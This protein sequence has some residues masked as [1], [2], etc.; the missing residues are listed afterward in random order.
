MKRVLWKAVLTGLMAVLFA[1]L[2]VSAQA[3]T[4]VAYVGGVGYETLEEAYAAGGNTILLA[5]NA[6]ITLSGTMTIDRAVTLYFYDSTITKTGNGSLFKVASGGSLTLAGS[7]TL[8]RPSGTGSGV[9]VNSGG[10]LVLNGV[11]ITGFSTASGSN[12]GGVLLNGEFVMNSGSITGCKSQASGIIG[13]GGAVWVGASAKFTM[14]GGTIS[15]NTSSGAGGAIYNNGNFEMR[16][17]KIEGNEVTSLAAAT[18]WG[19]A[20]YNASQTSSVTISG[21]EITGNIGLGGVHSRNGLLTVTGGAIYRN[22][23]KVGAMGSLDKELEYVDI[24]LRKTTLNNSPNKVSLCAANQMSADAYNL[25]GYSLYGVVGS[26]LQAAVSL[27]PTAAT[28]PLASLPADW[29]NYKDDIYI[30]MEAQKKTP[31]PQPDGVYIDGISGDDSESGTIPAQAVETLEKAVQMAKASGKPI[32]VSGTVSITANMQLSD[33][34]IKRAPGYKG[35]LLDVRSGAELTLKDVTIDGGREPNKPTDGLVRVQEDSVLRIGEGAI[36]E[37]NFTGSANM[38]LYGAGAVYCDG[39]KVFMEA[40]E[41]RNNESMNMGGGITAVH[42]GEVTVSGGKIQGNKADNFGGGICAIRGSSVVIKGDAQILGNSAHHGGGIQLGGGTTAEAVSQQKQTLTMQGGKIDGNRS[43]GGTGGGIYVQM[44]SVATI[45]AGYI[46]NNVADLQSVGGSFPYR[47]GGIYVNGGKSYGYTD[48]GE[49]VEIDD[50]VLQLFDVEIANNS[51]NIHGGGLAACPTATVEIYLNRG[52]V[53][54]GNKANR[55][56]QQV[57][58]NQSEDNGQEIY[59]SDFMLGGGMYQ[60]MWDEQGK[61]SVRAAQEQYQFPSH[62]AYPYIYL[63]NI[64]HPDDVSKAQ[65]LATTFITGNSTYTDNGGGIAA[66]GTVIIGDST[67]VQKLKGGLQVEKSW[68]DEENLAGNRP[69]T[70]TV[71]IQYGE[72]TLRGIELTAANDW[73]AVWND[74]PNEMM[75]QVNPVIK[76][77]EVRCAN[78][79]LDE[80]SVQVQYDATNRELYIA[81]TN[82]YSGPPPTGNLTVRKTVSGTGADVMRSF[83]FTI[84]LNDSTINGTYGDLVFTDGAVSFLLKHNESKTAA[85]LPL[86]VGYTV[87]ESSYANCLTTVGGAAGNQTSGT[88]RMNETITVTFNNQIDKAV[89]PATGDRSRLAMWMALAMMSGSMFVVLSSRRNGRKE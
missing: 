63:D 10:K 5:K 67:E 79:T 4:P 49:T 55:D 71:D 77:L 88:I 62:T 39:G 82:R 69:G 45:E 51:A 15:G 68:E 74:L 43:L 12:G 61:P 36:L 78:Y 16:G 89:L 66:N 25:D 21:G 44:N 11:D 80:N 22:G 13:G 50:G 46:T 56:A 20:I 8:T 65:Q 54:H 30:V 31:D 53:I 81:F 40:G 1:M 32:L 35:Y 24:L 17:G 6:N 23:C 70:V 86:G 14:N 48:Q 9:T 42:Q 47:G 64:C 3:V 33:V 34:T 59:L 28:W 76:V 26:K 37:N 19:G 72:Y 18:A 27:V 38:L 75:D 2:C 41:I 84:T 85:N 57:Y 58:I 29:S 60:W 52:G 83:N 73:R 7:G 87:T